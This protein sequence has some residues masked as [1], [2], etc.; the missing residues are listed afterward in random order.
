MDHLYAHHE[1]RRLKVAGG[2]IHTMGTPDY[3]RKD[4]FCSVYSL[5]NHV[6]HV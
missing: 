5:A 4:Y 3:F 6:S 1:T 2:F